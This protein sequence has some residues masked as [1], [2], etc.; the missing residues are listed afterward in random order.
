VNFASWG[1]FHP[2]G[3]MKAIYIPDRPWK[4]AGRRAAFIVNNSKNLGI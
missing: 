1:Y 2:I 3:K 4:P